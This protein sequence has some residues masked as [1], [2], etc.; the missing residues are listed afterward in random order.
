MT[1]L[2]SSIWSKPLK[3][4]CLISWYEGWGVEQAYKMWNM[5][6]VKV[7]WMHLFIAQIFFP[8]G[9]RT[10][11]RISTNEPVDL[12]FQDIFFAVAVAEIDWK[13]NKKIILWLFKTT[14]KSR[15]K[16]RTRNI[17][18]AYKIGSAITESLLFV[19]YLSQFHPLLFVQETQMLR[20]QGKGTVCLRPDLIPIETTKATT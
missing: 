19:F 13:Y 14:K 10:H 18:G 11:L 4:D 6:V 9:N 8:L 20:V 16:S 17:C 15:S 5:K 7:G 3:A 12:T 1:V 2:F